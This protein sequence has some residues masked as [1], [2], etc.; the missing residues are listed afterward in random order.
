MDRHR[1]ATTWGAVALA[2]VGWLGVRW[3]GDRPPV[4]P[5]VQVTAD[6]SADSVPLWSAGRDGRPAGPVTLSVATTLSA[7][8]VRAGDAQVSAL[9]LAG[10]GLSAPGVFPHRTLSHDPVDFDLTGQVACDKVPIP[11]PASAYQVQLQVRD[12]T[13]TSLATVPLRT[14]EAAVSRRVTYGCSTWLAA[15]DLTVTGVRAVVDPVATRVALTLTVANRGGRDGLVW[16]GDTAGTGLRVTVVNR[17]VPAHSTVTVELAV[18]L[19][20]CPSWGQT[21]RPVTATDTPLPLLGAIGVTQPLPDDAVPLSQGPI[22]VVLAPTAA[23]QLQDALVQ[24]CGGVASPVLLTAPGSSGYDARTRVLTARVLADLP[25]GQVRSVR[26]GASADP[27][28][29]ITALFVPSPWLVPDRSGQAGWTVRFA[30]P[31]DVACLGGGP[32][33]AMDVWT[34]VQTP[35]GSVRVAQFRLYAETLLPQAQLDAACSR[36]AG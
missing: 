32:Y 19:D 26:F 13:R 3:Y 33:L 7:P 29:G 9:G 5:P 15:R 25:P 34:K 4:A 36:A 14:A 24:A 1:R 30:V 31:P 12:G 6:R 10:P 2:V 27:G 20:L 22:G 8:D 16:L 23:A 17:R 11:V 21:G 18:A 28:S 35:G